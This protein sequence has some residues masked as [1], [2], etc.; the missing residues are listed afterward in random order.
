MEFL[1]GIYDSFRPDLDAEV[2]SLVEEAFMEADGI[3]EDEEIDEEAMRRRVDDHLSL[4]AGS[5]LDGLRAFRFFLHDIVT[6]NTGSLI[7]DLADLDA[8][9]ILTVHS[10]SRPRCGVKVNERRLPC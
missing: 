7:M 8:L 10:G 5:P 2:R 3:G 4:S 1:A 9:D 6:E